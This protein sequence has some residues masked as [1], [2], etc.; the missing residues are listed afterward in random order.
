M[1]DK[2]FVDTN[3]LLYARDRF[4][5]PKYERAHALLERL[6]TDRSGILS[7]QVLQEFCVNV[8]RKSERPLSIEETRAIVADYSRW[9]VVVNTAASVLEALD[10]EKRYK[11][12]FWD[13]LIIQAAQAAGATIL[14]SEDLS[15]G[16]TYG[17]VRVVNPLREGPAEAGPHV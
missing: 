4:A 6:W 2:H 12:S 15:D 5:G 13:A 7:T 17:S 1:S 11:V 9:T 10:L 14:Y 8:R 16:Q 3:I